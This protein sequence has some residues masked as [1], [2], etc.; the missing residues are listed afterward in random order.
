[1]IHDPTYGHLP[2]AILDDD[3]D[4]DDAYYDTPSAEEKW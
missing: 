3:E 2:I 4:E 1:M